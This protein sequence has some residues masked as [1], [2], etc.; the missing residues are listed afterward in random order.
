MAAVETGGRLHDSAR[1][2]LRVAAGD[3][4]VGEP[5][6]VRGA[7]RR[8]YLTRWT[9]LLS[10]ATQ[11]ALAATLVEDGAALLDTAQ[12][13]VRSSEEVLLDGVGMGLSDMPAVRGPGNVMSYAWATSRMM[14]LFVVLAAWAIAWAG[15]VGGPWGGPWR[16]GPRS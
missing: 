16:P 2:L 11:D 3:R 6:Y 13:R 9:T 1:E 12:E 8:A 15:P 10:V 4:A 7:V 14:P 5:R